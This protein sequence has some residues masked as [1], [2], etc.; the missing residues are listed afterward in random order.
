MMQTNS[1]RFIVSQRSRNI[2]ACP[3]PAAGK[4]LA[5]PSMEMNLSVI[6]PGLS[7]LSLSSPGLSRFVPVVTVNSLPSRTVSLGVRHEP[8]RA[9]ENL[10]QQH[11]DNA[12]DE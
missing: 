11:A 8:R 3:P 9:R 6:C 10:V 5:M 7:G 12:D 2:V 1:P 4:R